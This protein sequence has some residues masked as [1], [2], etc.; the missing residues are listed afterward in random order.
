MET[1]R[2]NFCA[3]LLCGGLVFLLLTAGT[4]HRDAAAQDGEDAVTGIYELN[5]ILVTAERFEQEAEEVP[6]SLSVFSQGTIS[7][8]SIDSV[9]ELDRYVPNLHLSSQGSPRFSVNAI[10][11]ISNTV[12]DDYFSSTIG[13][14]LDG[15]PLTEAEYSRTLGDIE[16]VEV[17]RGP[18]GTLYGRNTP[19]G[20]INLISRAPTDVVTGEFRGM[21]GNNGQL[22]TT[23]MISG[24]IAKGV[25]SGRAFFDYTRR[26]GF[27]D[28]TATGGG[29]DDQGFLTGSGALRFTPQAGT[30]FTLSGNVERFDEGAYAFQPFNSFK[31]RKVDILPPNREDR[32]FEGLTLNGSHELGF[33][34]LR[35]ITGYRSYKVLSDQDLGYNP[36]LAGIGGGRSD[37]IETGDQFSQEF[38]L[39][40][41]TKGGRMRWIGGAFYQWDEVDYDYLFD[42]PAFGPPSLSSSN[43]ER[44][45]IAAFGELTHTFFSNLDLTAGIRISNDSQEVTN[46]RPFSGEDDFTLVTPR[47]RA[48]YHFDEDRLGY[49]MATRGARS[50]GFNRLSNGDRFDPEYLWSYEAGLKT[51]WLGQT[52]T[53]NA[54]AFY[55]DW[56]DQQIRTFVSP[57]VTD[58]VNAGES[59]SKG[60]ELEVAW[61]PR[62]R[63]LVSGFFGLTD[64]EYD[65]FINR[66]GVDLAGN[67]LVNTPRTNG[68]ASIQYRFPLRSAPWYGRLRADYSYT[69]DQFF[70]AENR[71]EQPGYG[72]VN[73]HAGIEGDSFSVTGFVKNL[74]DED[75]RLYGYRDFLGFDLAIAGE[76]RLFGVRLDAKF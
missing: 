12:R 21:A 42:V 43:Y 31:R 39:T 57:G 46:N 11:G 35:S 40:G 49:V 70:D 33:A 56:T 6:A 29:I 64:A 14:Y 67:K 48:A 37:A 76:P 62:P 26:D 9:Q 27:T 28:Y 69:G 74:F 18:Q 61:R 16:R 51:Q 55:I 60:I 65:V 2:A 47:F 23:A 3:P 8:A 17:L 50:G 22:G 15:I 19:A 20:V 66:N 32:E 52:L 45:E 4:S 36:T 41:E 44:E 75:Y 25:L 54:A 5:R 34:T 1:A 30:E 59:H 58:I 68:G 38:R 53:V 73:L 10:R 63:L 7:D 71:L 13:V 72:L 24:P